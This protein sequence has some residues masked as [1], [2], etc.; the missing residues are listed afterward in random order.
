MGKKLIPDEIREK[1]SVIIERFNQQELKTTDVRY[2]ARFQ[3]IFLY[4]DRIT[5]ESKDC[6]AYTVDNKTSCLTDV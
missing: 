6:Q 1:A 5:Y 4:L 2:I 3:G